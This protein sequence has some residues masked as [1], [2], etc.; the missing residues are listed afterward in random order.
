MRS[1][2]INTFFGFCLFGIVNLCVATGINNEKNN[3]TPQLVN[4]NAVIKH[5]NSI[6]PNVN[7]IYSTPLKGVYAIRVNENIVYGDISSNYL[8]IGDIL[9]IYDNSTISA[10]ILTISNKTDN[11]NINAANFKVLPLVPLKSVNDT[12]IKS[13]CNKWL[14]AMNTLV[15]VYYSPFKGIYA[16]KVNSND[17]HSNLIVY[18][19]L[20]ND[21]YYMVGSFDS[22]LI[23]Q[24]ISSKVK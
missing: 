24:I 23:K 10:Q 22:D 11:A 15:D 16:L 1:K 3:F 5:F 19:A 2:I 9:N 6:L 12:Q 8:M 4:N 7:I 13:T 21:D 17:E 20:D 18:K 14:K